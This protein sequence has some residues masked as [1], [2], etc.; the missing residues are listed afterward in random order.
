MVGGSAS[1]STREALCTG[2]SDL[3]LSSCMALGSPE[4]LGTLVSRAGAVVLPS[5]VVEAKSTDPGVFFL[6][7][8]IGD[9]YFWEE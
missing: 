6:P 8:S 9:S 4:A 5:E 3:A 2:E 7:I 1:R